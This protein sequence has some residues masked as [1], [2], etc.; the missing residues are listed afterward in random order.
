MSTPKAGGQI[1]GPEHARHDDFVAV[2]YLRQGQLI[3]L[4][5]WTQVSGD[6]RYT[7]MLAQYLH[8]DEESWYLVINGQRAKLSRSEWAIFN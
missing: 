2:P 1:S 5:R 3:S 4:I 6:W 8:R 7:T